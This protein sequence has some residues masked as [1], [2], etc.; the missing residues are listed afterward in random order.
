ML[1]FQ[2]V[3]QVFQHTISTSHLAS[4]FSPRSYTRTC[5]T[6][7]DHQRTISPMDCWMISS[8][9]WTICDVCWKNS[10]PKNA[11]IQCHAVARWVQSNLINIFR[12]GNLTRDCSGAIKRLKPPPRFCYFKLFVPKSC[13]K[14]HHWKQWGFGRIQKHHPFT[15]QRFLSLKS[16]SLTKD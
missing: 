1:N 16:S 10:P 3:I 14:K 6:S 5:H 11:K 13:P 9:C 4:W 2:G 8:C 12:N 7:K 15:P